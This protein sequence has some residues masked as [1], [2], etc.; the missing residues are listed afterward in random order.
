MGWSIQ[1]KSLNSRRYTTKHRLKKPS[2]KRT[3]FNRQL[4]PRTA[5]KLQPM[6]FRARVKESLIAYHQIR[7]KNTLQ[8]PLI[9]ALRSFRMTRAAQNWRKRCS[10]A[11]L[12]L[13]LKWCTRQTSSCLSLSNSATKWSFGTITRRKSVL[14]SLSTKISTST[15]WNCARIWWLSCF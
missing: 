6:A 14:R 2:Y 15:M 10:Y 13:S 9:A 8:S 3:K 11:K 12:F 4:L 5:R 1:P 7:R